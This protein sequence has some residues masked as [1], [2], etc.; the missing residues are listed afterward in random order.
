MTSEPSPVSI[1]DE[2]EALVNVCSSSRVKVVPPTVTL[3]MPSVAETPKLPV[4][5]SLSLAASEPSGDR[6]AS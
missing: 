2:G 3:A 5:V 4:A 6:P 1:T